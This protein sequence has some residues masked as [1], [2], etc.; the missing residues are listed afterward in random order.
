MSY[1]SSTENTIQYRVDRSYCGRS[2]ERDESCREES[3]KS[4]VVGTVGFVR[5]RERSRI[6][7]S[8]FDIC[9]ERISGK[10][11]LFGEIGWETMKNSRERNSKWERRVR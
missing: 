4:P 8:S 3:L 9:R 7:D 6:V 11:G 10:F 5:S 2:D 1:D